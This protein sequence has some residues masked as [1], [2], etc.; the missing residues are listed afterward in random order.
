MCCT[1]Q[2]YLDWVS[3]CYLLPK[4]SIIRDEGEH[5]LRLCE[6]TIILFILWDHEKPFAMLSQYNIQ[7]CAPQI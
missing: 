5:G 6:G 3:E 2:E 7:N 1:G 4:D